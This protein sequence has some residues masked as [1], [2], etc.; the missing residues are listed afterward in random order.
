MC[1]CVKSNPEW[2]DAVIKGDID[3]VKK[4]LDDNKCSFDHRETNA[5]K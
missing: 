2:F 5:E 1:L 3:Y 4:N